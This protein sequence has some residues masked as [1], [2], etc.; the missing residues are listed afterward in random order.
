VSGLFQAGSKDCPIGSSSGANQVTLTF[1]GERPCATPE[2]CGGFHKGIL[3]NAGGSLRLF[4]IKGVPASELHGGDES[5]ISW[6]HLKDAAGPEEKYSS[7]KGVLVPVPPGG[8]RIIQLADDVTQ[9]PGA[10]QVG[11]WIAIATTSFSSVETE[12]VQINSLDSNG[13]GGTQ[14][15]LE[16]S[17]KHYH[18]GGPD[19]GDPSL[20]NFNDCSGFNYG[21]DERAEVGL[22]SRNIKLTATISDGD[23]NKHW[24]GEL[25]FLEGFTEVSIQGVQIE[26]FGKDT[27]G[28]YPIHFHLASDVEQKPLVN[29][30]SIHHSYNK[31]MTIHS[32]SNVTIENNVC[33]RIVGHMYYQEIGDEEGVRF[34]NNLGLGVMANHF[35][36]QA[37]SEAERAQ[38]IKD[39][40]WSGDNL[41]Q[42]DSPDYNGYD[43]MDIYNTDNQDNP[44]RGTCAKKDPNGGG[45]IQ[46]F[47]PFIID[48]QRPGACNSDEFYFEPNSA[49]WI[50]NP[51][52]D[53]IGNSIGGCQDVGRGYW[54]VPP[55]NR[56]EVPKDLR[57]IAH[58]P[59]GTFKNNRVHGCYSGLYGEAEFGVLSGQLFPTVDGTSAGKNIII[60]WDGFTATRNLDRGVWIRPVWQVLKN[61]RFATNRNSVTLVTSGGLDGNCPGCWLML[62]DS[63]LVGM[64][65]NNVDRWGPCKQNQSLYFECIG[66]NLPAVSA[67]NS[68]K[69]F[70]SP[71]FNTS[72]YMIY[73]GP[74]LIFRDR[75][76]NFNKDITSRL[77]N[78]DKEFLLKFSS[79]PN[80]N[81][82][83]VY[84]GDAALGW[85]QNNQSAYPTGTESKD[86]TWDN[87]DLR[88][89]VYTEQVNFGDFQDG[90]ANTAIIDL[91]GSLA[92][93]HVVNADGK[94][95]KGAHPISLNNLAFN[96]ASNSVDECLSEGQQDTIAED[97]PT[98]L[99]SAGSYATLE[100][101]TMWPSPLPINRFTKQ[102]VTFIKD[103]QDFDEHSEMDL[104][105]RNGLGVWEPK[106]ISGYGYTALA[107]TCEGG[108]CSTV[109]PDGTGTSGFAAKVF[110]GLTDAIKPVITED[111]PFFVRVGIC[112]SN[113]DG[114]HPS[115]DFTVT[116]GYRSYGGGG[117]NI[118]DVDL[119]QYFNALTT[120]YMGQTCHNLEQQNALNRDDVTGCPANGVT[121]VPQDGNCPS[122][123]T[124]GTDVFG[125]DACIYPKTTL[126]KADSIDELTLADGSPDLTK[127]FYDDKKAKGMLFLNVAQTIQNAFG[128]SPLGSCSDPASID[129]DPNCPDLEKGESYYACPAAGCIDYLVRVNDT[130]YDQ[131]PS[132][133]T[134]IYPTYAQDPPDDELFLALLG[135]STIVQTTEEG[136][137][138]GGFPHHVAVDPPD[139]ELTMV[140][141]TTL[142]PDGSNSL[143][144]QTTDNDLP[145]PVR[146][147]SSFGATGG[148][149]LNTAGASYS[150]FSIVILFMSLL[151]G[152]RVMRKI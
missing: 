95:V 15:G 9:G 85:F 121:A 91:D 26:K 36:V 102:T 133:C 50:I 57:L 40:W 68:S 149:S 16:Q 10:W 106:V 98:A 2:N 35:Q 152:W 132:T 145:G 123:S 78:E 135:T 104:R 126:T 73:D 80:A 129:D 97:R 147:P 138:D 140:G 11:D 101:Q 53:L 64:S 74:I 82:P 24:G 110:L 39:F 77:T 81:I 7:G 107:S 38:K 4:G 99:M 100:L 44:V 42:V 5:G 124:N 89:Q 94:S 109:P 34:L 137:K 76:V 6:S 67:P 141:E 23:N 83:G 1:T 119:Q 116:R 148:C 22:L 62:K 54:Y 143:R 28:S 136:G 49:F 14:V 96:H 75:F 3:V 56:D 13:S 58:T 146:C 103:Q 33:V 144:F 19:P 48:G 32:T 47:N 79:Y 45:F 151:M 30:N 93:F 105:S 63:V 46:T 69:G 65:Q 112:F 66:P 8:T 20:S 25:R 72:G 118:N 21:V 37:S 43:G 87:V 71:H 134:D 84:E 90:D 131:G 12:I 29:A 108:T 70:P 86:L 61:G 130:T 41:G 114:S 150:H 18:F 27:L 31:C 128:P 60:N 113:V 117:A 51:G 127:Y 122:P 17:L 92:G 115:N 120:R 52:T 139:C 59:L 88:H 55:Q 111:D 125:R 142:N